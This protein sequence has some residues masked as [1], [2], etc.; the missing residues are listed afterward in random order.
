[1]EQNR[2]L[3]SLDVMRGITI[4][5]MILVNNPGSWSHIYT[6]LE[7]AQWNG[8][9]PTD[10][11]FPFFMFV[12]GISMYFSLK[13][14]D[15]KPSKAVLWKILR[16]TILI[17]VVGIA[18]GWFSI[19]CSNVFNIGSDKPL[20]ERFQHGIF[21]F[22][23]IRI[24]GVLQRLALVYGF[25]ALIV[26]FVRHRYVLWISGAILLVYTFILWFGNGFDLSAD[27]VINI[28]DRSLLGVH[29]M[30]KETLPDGTIIP[31][32][33]EGL[34][35]TLPGI[36]HVLLGF[37]VGMMISKTKENN[38]RLQSI[39][40]F[41]TILLFTGLLLS[42]GIP[43]NKKV[44]SP[45]FVLVTCGFGSLLFALLLWIIDVKGAKKWSVFFES[46]GV[47]PLFVYVLADFF[48]I[49]L[50]DIRFY[51]GSEVVSLQG[52]FYHNA[53]LPFFVP[54]FASLIYALLF[55]MLIWV[56]AHFL[57]KK[58]IYIKI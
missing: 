11:V 12:M 39:F 6:P 43:L 47:N 53:L 49:L 14:Y 8:M 28:V 30:Y 20:L 31:F 10:L 38:A 44:W 5:G 55:V 21:P 24:L 51:N 29:H 41:G 56:F 48:A 32:D 7:H 50:G 13:K 17:F 2:R 25:G 34:L 26:V 57:Y 42:Y 3:L 4:S 16:R 45:T 27:N 15:F 18:I 58:K 1:M 46:F 33:P 19:L 36:A 22:E 9:T 35:S 54:E 40:I 52:Y 23:R 37:Y